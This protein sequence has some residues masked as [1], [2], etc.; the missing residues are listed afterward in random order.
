VTRKR[1]KVDDPLDRGCPTCGALTRQGCREVLGEP[2]PPLVSF[3]TRLVHK[4][5][6]EGDG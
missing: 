4:A 3:A 6:I 1:S 2:R 5:R